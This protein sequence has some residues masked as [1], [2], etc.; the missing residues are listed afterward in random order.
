MPLGSTVVAEWSKVAG[1]GEVVF[2]DVNAAETTGRFTLPGIYVLKLLAHDGLKEA[3]DTVEV[4]VAAFC[5]VDSPPNL[6]AWWPGNGNS[7]DA[8]SGQIARLIKWFSLSAEGKVSSA[9]T[10]MARNDSVRVPPRGESGRWDVGQ[11]LG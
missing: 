7:T 9:L 1:P 10:S 11:R 4:R 2:G 8:V 5:R 3:S 6:V